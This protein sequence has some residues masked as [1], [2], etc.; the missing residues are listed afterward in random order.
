MNL[1]LDFLLLVKVCPDSVYKNYGAKIG[2]KL[3]LTKRLGVGT[4]IT[5]IKGEICSDDAYND[6]VA[7]MTTL[8]K[9]AYEASIGIKINACTDI[10]G[11]SLFRSWI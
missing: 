4:I 5:A 3:V 1:N 11:F 6:A 10:T 9:Y 2:D 7:S 8:N